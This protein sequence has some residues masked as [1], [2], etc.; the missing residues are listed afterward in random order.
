MEFSHLSNSLA[1]DILHLNHI[2]DL[3]MTVKTLAL[4]GGTGRVGQQVI[5][6][7]I[8]RGY[9]LRVLARTPSKVKAHANVTV[10]QGNALSSES[11]DTLLQGANAVVSTLGPAGMNESIKV[12]KLSAK[13]MPCYNSTRA[14]A[15]PA[16]KA[17]C[18]S[19][20]INRRTHSK[21][22]RRSQRL[23]Y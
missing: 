10:V 8:E 16:V 19:F 17:W 4:I 22:Y 1:S 18:S 5:T 20:R 13:E 21:P 7:A 15:A 11:L 6:E 14:F 3:I 12:A 2:G 9:H 23:L